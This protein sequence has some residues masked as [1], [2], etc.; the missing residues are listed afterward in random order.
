MT[1]VWEQ[2]TRF[3][4]AMTWEGLQSIPCVWICCALGTD[5][6]VRAFPVIDLIEPCSPKWVRGT[7]GPWLHTPECHHH[8]RCARQSHK[9]GSR[10]LT[11]D[12][13]VCLTFSWPSVLIFAVFFFPLFVTSYILIS[14]ACVIIKETACGA[15]VF[16][17]IL[18]VSQPA[19]WPWASYI[20]PIC[21]HFC[22]WVIG[23]VI[24]T[25]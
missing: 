10:A 8:I 13:P 20:N 18:A 4:R 12:L 14:D 7:L 21:L 5:E 2:L 24:A 3:P 17:Q 1:W 6:N 23:I 19:V 15:R 11:R 22:S 9:Q 16:T 25:S